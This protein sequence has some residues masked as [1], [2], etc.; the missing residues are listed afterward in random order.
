MA[1][2]LYVAQSHARLATHVCESI[3]SPMHW[4]LALAT[5]A[6]FPRLQQ[7]DR[8]LRWSGPIVCNNSTS[9]YITSSGFAIM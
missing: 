5:A 1:I 7:T 8:R 3:P 4:A 9:R 6:L 2:L